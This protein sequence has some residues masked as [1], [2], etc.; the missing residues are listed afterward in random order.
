[1]YFCL[2]YV[3]HCY[4]THTH[5]CLYVTI[6]TMDY[7]WIPDLNTKTHLYKFSRQ[8][9]DCLI[10][11]LLKYNCHVRRSFLMHLIV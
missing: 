1:M 4:E 6:G 11:L 5:T 7:D 3:L 2:S 8:L 9:C 10:K